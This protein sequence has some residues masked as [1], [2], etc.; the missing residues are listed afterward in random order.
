MNRKADIPLHFFLLFAA[1]LIFYSG[2]QTKQNSDSPSIETGKLLFSEDIRYAK[3]FSIDYFEEFTKVTIHNPWRANQKPYSQ[4][5][6]YRKDSLSSIKQPTEASLKNRNE[7]VVRITTPLTS[8]MVNSFSFFEFLSQLGELETV[9]GVTDGFRIYNHDIRSR[10]K[11]GDIIDLGDPFNP[12]IEKTILLNPQAIQYSAYA[13]L[14]YYGEL[15]TKAG[16]PI[17][18]TLEWMENSPLARAEWIKL[19]AAFFNKR[20]L[21][22][23]IFNNIE[24]RYL[25]VKE[26]VANINKK[27]S[28]LSGDIFQGTWYVPGGKSFN[29]AFFK[30]AGLNYRYA[31]SRESGS[32]GLD[33]EAI[34]TEFAQS[35]IWLG[36]DAESY[37]ELVEKDVKYLLLQSVKNR[38]VFNNRNRTTSSG[39]NDF[40]ESAIAHPDLILS[41]LVK[42]GY[43][44]LLPGYSFS[45]IKPLRELREIIIEN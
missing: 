22:D 33:I 24:H 15:L 7:N 40:F 17:I 36:C 4:Y 27:E 42:A 31:N 21:A 12:N 10:L 16:F 44:D 20:D 2:C 19:T 3:G 43:P 39:G 26:S 37:A 30:D 41:D 9:C 6:L 18:Y 45:Y 34:L 35:D 8:L 23:S 13:E 5:Y 11:N 1:L 29:A 38:R 28:L 14:D 25:S 32:I